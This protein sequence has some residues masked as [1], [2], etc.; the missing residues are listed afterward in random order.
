MNPFEG[1]LGQEKAVELLLQAVRLD[2][3]APAYLFY[4][5]SGIGRSIAAKSFARLLLCIGLSSHQQDS[6]LRKLESG[7]HPDLLWVKPTY[8]NKGELYTASEA[9]QLG[10]QYKTPPKIRIEQIRNITQFLNRPAL[11]ATRQVVVVEDAQTMAEAPANALLKTLE[12]PGNA[13]LI[14][15]AP[16][17]DSL[18]ST[19]VSR[20]Q[21]IQFYSLSAANL[22]TVLELN[23]DRAILEHPEIL[24]I[25]QGSPG[26]AIAA[27]NQLQTIPH[28]LLQQLRRSITTPLEAFKLAQAVTS[29]IDGQ[30]QLWLLDYLQ[31]YYWQQ[32]QQIQLVD[33][34]ERTRQY[35]LSHVQPRLAW[36]CMLLNLLQH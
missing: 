15:I 7:N 3:V 36:E 13:S 6:T 20:C 27:W 1:L 26:V 17:G 21:R 14:L 8:L 28:E 9:V 24:A 2:R 12:E 33:K 34:W 19:L 10:L 16:D 25:A 32:N 29:E 18:L 4:G 11:E 31:Y 22:K 35:L 30:T 5:S 23:G